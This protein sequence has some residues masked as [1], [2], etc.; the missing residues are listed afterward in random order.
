MRDLEPHQR[1]SLF[2]LSIVTQLARYCLPQLSRERSERIEV[3]PVE[4]T[5]Q[6]WL[7]LENLGIE[8]QYLVDLEPVQSLKYMSVFQ[9]FRFTKRAN[10]M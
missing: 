8:L 6:N 3:V 1:G 5:V 7:F 4:D 2:G 9:N 10:N